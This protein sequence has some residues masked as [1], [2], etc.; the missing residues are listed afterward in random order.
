MIDPP[1]THHY[2]HH[3]VLP[4]TPPPPPPY[5]PPHRSTHVASS[6]HITRIAQVSRHCGEGSKGCVP[7][8]HHDGTKITLAHQ[9]KT[10]R[11]HQPNAKHRCP[12]LWSGGR[13]SRATTGTSEMLCAGPG[14]R[15]LTTTARVR[16][17]SSLFTHRARHR[18]KTRV[19]SPVNNDAP[20]DESH[21]S[22]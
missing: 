13:T 6:H 4:H 7:L 20:V 2:H 9:S 18:T 22:I 19:S 8:G 5:T 1:Y 17:L 15:P 11:I 16:A 3:P 14:R 10:A 12:R 21:H